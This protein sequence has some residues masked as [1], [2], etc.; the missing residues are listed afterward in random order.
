MADPFDLDRFVEA[1][2]P[3][4]DDVVAELRRGRKTSHWMWFVF[5]QLR[6]LG[7][8]AMAERYG[9]ASLAEA[10]AYWGHPV[11]GPR[12]RECVDLLLAVRGR[13]AREILGSPDDIKLRSCLTLFERA[14]PEEP[15]FGRALDRYFDGVRDAITNE[16]LA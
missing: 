7:R 11:L 8:S 4:Y 14:V 5:P 1:Q 3:V 16:R 13:T 15:A 2:D 9:I 6:G 10:G 12:L